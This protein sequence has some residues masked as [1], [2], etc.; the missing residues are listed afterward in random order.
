M[1]PT[2]DA[3]KVCAAAKEGI[4]LKSLSNSRPWKP[5]VVKLQKLK[6]AFV[7]KLA[8]F[9]IEF[10]GESISFLLVFELNTVT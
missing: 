8:M 4:L 3:E 10:D 6:N 7:Q 2:R 5:R 9:T 1:R